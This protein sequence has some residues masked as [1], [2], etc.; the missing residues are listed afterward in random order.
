MTDNRLYDLKRFAQYVKWLSRD[1]GDA[2]DAISGGFIS[3]NGKLVTNG[4]SE[5]NLMMFL[6]DYITDVRDYCNIL[7]SIY[8]QLEADC[9]TWEKSPEVV[10]EV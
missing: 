10:W 7:D 2:F 9:D 4:L 6:E 3:T 1:S 8:K 5:R